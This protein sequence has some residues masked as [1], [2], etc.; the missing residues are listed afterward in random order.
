MTDTMTAPQ[1][2]I[3]VTPD[4]LREKVD[5]ISQL[6]EQLDAASGS[7]TAGKRALAN[8]LASES[9]NLWKEFA[10]QIVSKI[11]AQTADDVSQ[12]AGVFTGVVSSL[13]EAF[14]NTVDE[15]LTTEVTSRQENR[16]AVSPDQI[17]E[18]TDA[19]KTLMEQYKAL[20]GIL[21]LFGQ[22]TSGIPEPKKRTGARGKRGPRVLQGYDFFID[23]EPRSQHQ[24][25]LSSIANTVCSELGWKTKELRD[26]L[27]ESGID[28]ENPPEDF[29]GIMLPEPVSKKLSWKRRTVALDEDGEEE[30][31]DDDD[32]EADEDTE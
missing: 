31:D 3:S 29:E 24:N 20:K 5:E 6:D 10:D 12:L 7:E 30:Y 15:F 25:S 28:L 13:N 8:G 22:D 16:E 9:E 21:D 27:T 32:D 1:G 4:A 11:Q 23:D 2:G 19:R 18:W 14:R 26:F 17:K